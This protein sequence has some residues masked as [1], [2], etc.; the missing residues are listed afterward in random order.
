MSSYWQ[1]FRSEKAQL[2]THHSESSEEVVIRDGN[3]EF[4]REAGAGNNSK[5][6]YQ[7]ASG[8]PVEKDS[9]LGYDVNWFTIIFLNVG[10]MIGTGVFSTPGSI[11][12]G[13]GSVGLSLM[14]WVIGFL[15]AAAGMC[16]YLELASYF[17]N[18]SGAQVVYLEQGFPRPKYF[19]PT[20]YAM[21]NVLLAFSS[22]NAIVLATYTFRIAGHSPSEWEAKGVALAGYTLATFV[23]I[24]SNKWSLRFSNYVGV[25]K[26]GILIFISITGFVVLGGGIKS[27]PDPGKN[28]RNAFEG[29]TGDAS[30]IVRALVRVNYAYEGYANA[31]N[32]VNEIKNPI[33]TIRWAGPLS[34][35]IVAILYIF[36]NIAYFAAVPK[37]GIIGSQ[38]AAAA[39]FFEAVFGEGNAGR[40]LSFLILVSSFGNLVSNLI[41]AGRIIRECG[42]Q[43]VLPY[44]AFWA[45]TQPFGTPLGP[46]LLKYV[47][48]VLM[49]VAPPFGDAFDFVVDL[50]S[51]PDAV[52]MLVMALGLFFI[53]RHRKRVNAGAPE[54]KA[55]DVIVIFWIL[56]QVLLLV[57]PWVPPAGGIYA[58]SVSFFYATY[59]FTG[60]GI[61]G[62]CA[63]YYWLWIHVLPKR[64]KYA[65]RQTVLVLDSGA[66]TH[67]LVKVP[68]SELEEWDSKHDVVGKQVAGSGSSYEPKDGSEDDG[69]VRERILV[70]DSKK[71]E[72]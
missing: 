52:F 68:L 71:V 12:K 38:T 29:T 30:G 24:L 9:P 1:K 20:A 11:L 40:G 8:A 66:Q 5:P 60:L 42:R 72:L 57:M 63:V 10:Q 37:E 41:G 7:E 59:C 43:G 13:L 2:A 47:L 70:D 56:I 26:I 44:P 4:T 22:S 17:P 14:F 55:W 48:T 25:V 65:I 34:L 33:K 36:V 51:Y 46:Y 35:L 27:I 50:K 58:G 19:F 3:L 6:S 54:F 15:V 69:V 28:F 61:L 64:G 67:K 16:T 23:V 32:V 31:F 62:A 45:S 21:L 18:R 49:I 39:I 53:R